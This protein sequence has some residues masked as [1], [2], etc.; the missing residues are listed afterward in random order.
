METGFI[1]IEQLWLRLMD[2]FLLSE[3]FL[4]QPEGDRFEMM[5]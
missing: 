3:Q 1:Y 5:I 4:P 2:W